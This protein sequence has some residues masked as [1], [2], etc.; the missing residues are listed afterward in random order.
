M[1]NDKASKKGAGR[2]GAGRYQRAS[3]L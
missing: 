3:R 1:L 2:A